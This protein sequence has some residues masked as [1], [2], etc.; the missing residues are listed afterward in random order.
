MHLLEQVEKST[1]SRDMI[2]SML[3]DIS[4]V[5]D[6]TFTNSFVASREEY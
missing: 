5:N 6:P 3:A 1:I 2:I 4:S